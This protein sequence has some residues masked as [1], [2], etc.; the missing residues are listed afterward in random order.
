MDFV[1]RLFLGEFNFIVPVSY[2][3][4]GILVAIFIFTARYAVYT[5]RKKAFEKRSNSLNKKQLQ[6]N[7]QLVKEENGQAIQEKMI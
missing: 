1:K 4:S 2:M 3:I 6:E 5:K 7:I